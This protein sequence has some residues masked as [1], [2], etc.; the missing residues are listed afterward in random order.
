LTGS[1]VEGRLT[2]EGTY[3]DAQGLWE[4]DFENSL[5]HGA[6]RYHSAAGWSRTGDFQQ[7]SFIEHDPSAPDNSGNDETNENEP[8]S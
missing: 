4:G 3:R 6:G 2:G 8:P 7:G 1:F 5:P